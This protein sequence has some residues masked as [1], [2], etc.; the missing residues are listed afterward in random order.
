MYLNAKNK[1]G[2]VT[3]PDGWAEVVRTMVWPADVI[4]AGSLS[5]WL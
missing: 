5:W 2:M 4:G 3:E 1:V